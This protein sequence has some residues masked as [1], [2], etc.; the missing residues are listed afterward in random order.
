M[1]E[2]PDLEDAAIAAC[3]RDHYGLNATQLEF[4]PLGADRQT[5]VYRAV[6]DD[7]GYFVKLR[8]GAFDELT[9]VV[10]KLLHDQ[11]I[12]AVIAPLATR[13]GRLWAALGDFKLTAAP[14]VAGRDGYEVDLTDQQW[15]EF[16][17][18]LKTIHAATMPRAVI[19]RLPRETYSDQWRAEVRR[20]MTL[21]EAANFVD[22]V[23]AELAALLRDQRAVVERLVGRAEALAADLKTRSLPLILCHADL[24]AGNL[25]IADEGRLY[26]VDWDTLILAPKERDLMFAGGGLFAGRRSPEEEEALFYR[27]Y[28]NIQ[29]D[30]AAL[31][32][33]RCERIVQDV[34]AY[35]EAILLTDVGGQD[36]A[37][38]LRQLTS[39]FQPGAVIDVAIKSVLAL[40]GES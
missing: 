38:G 24:H 10:P 9:I 6:A 13:S 36:R 5:A 30:A 11:G 4:L 22:P 12:E 20:F 3:L 1:L 26:V 33:Y 25:L 19:D 23:A 40:L 8:G 29:I 31:V 17:R 32:Y 2:K 16:G 39:Q 34:A 7:A 15:V 35:C 14:F 37:N 21:V 28:G 18:T 27:G